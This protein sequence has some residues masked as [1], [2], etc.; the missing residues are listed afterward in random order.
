MTDVMVTMWNPTDKAVRCIKTL[1]EHSD[2]VGRIVILDN[3]SKIDVTYLN[4]CSD[5]ADLVVKVPRQISLGALWN[6]A[7]ETAKTPTVVIS[8]DDIVITP[9]WLPPLQKAVE[10]DPGIGVVQPYNT[11]QGIPEN[12]P[13]NYKRQDRVGDIPGSNFIGCCFMVNTAIYEPLKA[14]DRKRWDD[15]DTF[16]YFYENYYPLGREDQDFYRRVREAGFSTVTAFE[17]YVHHWSGESM[18]R[19]TDFEAF[20]SMA[21]MV[22]HC[23]WADSPMEVS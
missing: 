23:R 15:G 6:L 17:S 12:F 5:L 7:M 14:F 11:L 8:N 1:R 18:K 2:G 13:D 3:A 21:D 20:K 22:F 9:D 16:T 10:S 4:E 19:W